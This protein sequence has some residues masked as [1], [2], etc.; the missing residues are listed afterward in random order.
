MPD[1]ITITGLAL[2]TDQLLTRVDQLLLGQVLVATQQYQTETADEDP[3]LGRFRLNNTTL[4]NV[5]AGYFDDQDTGGTSIAALIDT[6]DDSSS[7]V[8]GTLILKSLDN[9]DHWAAFRV[10]GAVVNGTGYRKLTLAHIV[11]NG[12]WTADE[13]FSQAFYR[14]GDVG[15]PNT[16][17][18]GTVEE[19]EADAEIIGDAPNQTLNLTI[20]KGDTGDTGP[21]PNITIGTVEEGDAAATLIG[22]SPNYFLNLTLPRGLQGL[23]GPRG[24][25]VLWGSGEPDN[26]IGSNNDFYI[27]VGEW[28]IYGPKTFG[29]W[30]A[31]VSLIGPK[32]DEG[33]PGED[34]NTILNGSGPPGA[35]LGALDDWYIDRAA[36]QIYGPKT[37][38]G[39]GDPQDIRGPAGAGSGDVT[40][41]ATA[42]NNQLAAFDGST[43]KLIKMAGI[44]VAGIQANLDARTGVSV[45]PSATF[46]FTANAPPVYV[47]IAITGT[48]PASPEVGARCTFKT[49]P[50]IGPEDLLTIARN[51]SPIE[52]E[53]ENLT[54]S[55]PRRSGGLL[56]V[57][58]S[59]GWRVF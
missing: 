28:E 31:G 7:A 57:G 58:G 26:E 45:A 15:T 54:V 56:F 17:T 51:G 30:P 23:T 5:T 4:A 6:Y 25:S 18:I 8:K 44:T 33:E 36:L 48:L 10:S 59:I 55:T 53:E 42:T 41:P 1:T 21:P 9:E 40:G 29:T 49:G 27:D 2:K 22:T 19:G 3:G 37:V 12:T 47:D 34:A 46:N 11:S 50:N 52:G 38:V 16:L 14:A 13:A 35:G 39:W 20:P 32:G 43:G 24:Y